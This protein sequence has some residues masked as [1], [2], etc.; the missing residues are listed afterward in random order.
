MDQQSADSARPGWSKLLA[1][2]PAM[3]RLVAAQFS[4]PRARSEQGQGSPVLVIPG[5][6]GSDIATGLLRRSLKACGFAPYRWTLGFNLGARRK[7]F[8]R[9]LER[10]DRVYDKHRRPL[11]LVGWSLGGLYAR[12][13]AK[14]RPDKVS[15]VITLGTPFSRSL[16]LTNARKLYDA[17]NDHRVEHPPFAPD[18]G[19]K[20]AARTIAM[21]SRRDG[22]VAPASARGLRHEVDQSVE[23]H[24]RHHEYLCAPEAIAAI[25]TALSHW[26]SAA[27]PAKPLRAATLAGKELV[28][29]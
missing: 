17:I 23:L 10:I 27:P 3:A 9:L 11:A 15:L 7:P 14:R 1:E 29:A 25:L 16:R 4:A 12:E 22:L 28:E 5:F 19:A 18:P 21:W 20:P 6:M 26:A 2:I 8:D 13:L 24:C